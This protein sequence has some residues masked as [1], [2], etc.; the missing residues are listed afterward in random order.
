[1]KKHQFLALF[2]I[3]LICFGEIDA[4]NGHK[5]RKNIRNLK[6]DQTYKNSV[7]AIFVADEKGKTIAEFNPDMPLLTASTMK[8]ITTGLAINLFGPDYRFTTKIGYTGTV[9]DSLLNG[10]LYIIGGGDPTLGSADTVA[11]PIE[12]IFGKWLGFIKKTGIKRISGNIIADDSFFENEP[13]PD[14]WSW[15]NIGESYGSAP[16]GLSYCENIQYIKLKPGNN[17]GDKPDIVSVYPFIPEMEYKTDKLISDNVKGNRISYHTSGLSRVGELSGRLPAGGKIAEVSVSNKFPALSCAYHF[18]EFLLKNGIESSPEIFTSESK[19]P[20]EAQE[21]IKIIGETYSKELYKIINV[22]NHISNNFYA[23]TLFKLIGR[24]INGTGSYD[25]SAVAVRRLLTN[26]GLSLNGFTSVDGSGLSRQDYVSA[27]FFC[28]YFLKMKESTNF[29]PFF[30]SLPQPGGP[31]TLKTVLSDV[32]SIKK[33]AIHAKSGSLSSVK[34]YA[35][36]AMHKRGMYVFAILTN[37]YQMATSEM[38]KAIESF[39]KTLIH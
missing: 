1:M 20:T 13:V 31:G 35:G 22:T 16:S 7:I 11:F 14:S 8:T 6:K 39:M 25:S 5:I 23:E 29:A 27:R 18:R 24:N 38:M 19:V 33:S 9:E 21:S 34:C 28:N 4:Q 12:D 30:S 26:M 15:G 37:N 17:K 36:Y 2:F 32:D 10:D 3:F